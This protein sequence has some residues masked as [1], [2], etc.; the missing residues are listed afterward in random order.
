MGHGHALDR[1][2]KWELAHGEPEL[3][4][5][6]ALCDT[7]QAFLD[8]GA[9]RGIYSRYASRFAGKVVAVEAH[10]MLIG[11]LRAALGNDVAIVPVALSSSEG[12]AHLTVP[13]RGH[14]DVDTRSSLQADANPGF[15]VRTIEVPTTTIDALEIANLGLI[16]ID[17]EGHEYEVIS[18]AVVTLKEQKPA[19]II[20]CEERHNAGSVA[21]LLTFMSNHGYSG[22]FLHRGKLRSTA[23][24]DVTLFQSTEDAA[25]VGGNNRPRDYVNNFLFIHPDNGSVLHRV[26]RSL[27]A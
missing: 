6:P 22:W 25:N 15:D 19:V 13:V 14:E 4:L 23:E 10:P 3:K 12:V 9:N 11:R 1:L 8:V 20:E 7:S 27:K 17:V 5:L 21:R 18:G 26:E 24:Y 16:K 2:I